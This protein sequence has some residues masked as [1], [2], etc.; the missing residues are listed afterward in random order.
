VTGR[1][2]P[3]YLGAVE[4]H[5][6]VL[7]DSHARYRGIDVHHEHA[8]RA[9]QLS[10]V[11]ESAFFARLRYRAPLAGVLSEKVSQSNK[12]CGSFLPHDRTS[13]EAHVL[14]KESD[15]L[16]VRSRV[17]GL[18]CDNSNQPSS[19]GRGPVRIEPRR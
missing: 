16:C 4:P 17:R 9:V 6:G 13:Q 2:R 5:E 19:R 12:F 3:T 8:E 14:A 1:G 7:F 11:R 15:E 18:F 10:K